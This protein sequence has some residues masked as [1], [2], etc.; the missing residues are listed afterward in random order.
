MKHILFWVSLLTAMLVLNCSVAAQL[1]QIVTVTN[2][3]GA[4]LSTVYISPANADKWSTNL[5]TKDKLLNEEKFEFKQA[6]DS[7]NCLFDIKFKGDDGQDYYM[8]NLNLCTS[9][10]VTLMIIPEKTDKTDKTD[11]MEDAKDRR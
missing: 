3:T 5:A 7:R 11:K 9:A 6:V 2:K 1:I 4:S 10:K 8:K